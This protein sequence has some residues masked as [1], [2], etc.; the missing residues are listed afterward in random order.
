MIDPLN[1]RSCPNCG[2][3][4]TRIAD[5]AL[6]LLMQSIHALNREIQDLS[7]YSD[8]EI[9]G[10]YECLSK[11]ESLKRN[12]DR[13]ACRRDNYSEFDANFDHVDL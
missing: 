11:L 12:I 13:E 5:K 4:D 6:S 9:Q 8:A 10:I 1:P 3:N 2:S 7:G